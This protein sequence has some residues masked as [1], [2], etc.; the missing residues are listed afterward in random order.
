MHSESLPNCEY[1]RKKL[2]FSREVTIRYD[3]ELNYIS[4][5]Y[6]VTESGLTF[7]NLVKIKYSTADL[8]AHAQPYI[9]I[10]IYI[11]SHIEPYQIAL[12]LYSMNYIR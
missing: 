1:G 11:H 9:Y 6:M 4:E 12:F 10:Y 7:V 2:Q 5:I 8:Y 3:F